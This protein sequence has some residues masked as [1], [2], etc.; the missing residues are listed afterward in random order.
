MLCASCRCTQHV[1]QP[2]HSLSEHQMQKFQHPFVV[3]TIFRSKLRKITP[4]NL[5]GV[6]NICG[7]VMW[8]WPWYLM[9]IRKSWSLCRPRKGPG[10]NGNHGNPLDPPLLHRIHLLHNAVPQC[11]SPPCFRYNSFDC[12]FPLACV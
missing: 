1:M 12:L 3:R 4:L 9:A 5:M 2:L 7:C 8:V 6:V 11:P 10:F